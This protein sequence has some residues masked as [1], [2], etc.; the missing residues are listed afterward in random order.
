MK[1]ITVIILMIIVLALLC[2]CG[3]AEIRCSVNKDNTAEVNIFLSID[4]TNLN[5]Y[6]VDKLRVEIS[7]LKDH[8]EDFG[9]DFDI[10]YKLDSYEITIAKTAQG[11]S[12]E[13]AVN[14]LLDMMGDDASPFSSVEGGYSEANLSDLYNIAATVDLTNIVDYDYISTLKQEQQDRI[15]DLMSTFTGTVTLDLFGT[16]VEYKG[17]LGGTAN[18]VELSLNE[19]SEIYSMVEIKHAENQAEYDALKA[20][21]TG[22]ETEKDKYMTYVFIAAGAL[23]AIAIAIILILILRKKQPSA[24]DDKTAKEVSNE[25]VNSEKTE[26]NESENP[27]A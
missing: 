6:E 18:T 10:K 16:T 19:P 8:L 14:K 23:I 26:E 25:T 27:K 12:P 5:N 13:D 3:K 11:T 22:L 24:K 9:Y 21:I 4:I 20:E 2:S 1:K 15:A 7:S 17:I